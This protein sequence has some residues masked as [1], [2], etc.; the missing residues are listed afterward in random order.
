MCPACFC[1]LTG[2]A[3]DLATGPDEIRVSATNHFDALKDAPCPLR[4]RP[5]CGNTACLVICHHLLGT[6]AARFIL[7]N[8]T[9]EIGKRTSRY[10]SCAVR[11]DHHESGG[12]RRKGRLGVPY[13]AAVMASSV[14]AAVLSAL[15]AADSL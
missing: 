5:I 11:R 15:L 6:S 4:Y 10:S 13:A 12:T 2:L 1:C 9:G 8:E 7:A 3:S 14:T